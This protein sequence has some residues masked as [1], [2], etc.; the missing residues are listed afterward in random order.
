MTCLYKKQ[1]PVSKGK[2][3][4]AEQ[5]ARALTGCGA[6][7]QYQ[8]FYTLLRKLPL[9]LREVFQIKE[10]SQIVTAKSE[11]CGPLEDTNSVSFGRQMDEEKEYFR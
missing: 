11:S 3:K 9:S 8:H 5:T 4:V 1:N 2:A 6:W 7:C 10:V